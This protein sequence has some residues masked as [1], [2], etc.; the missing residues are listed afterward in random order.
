MDNYLEYIGTNI[1]AAAPTTT[2]IATGR[3]L[4]HSIVINKPLA[5]GVI[6]IYDGITAGGTL[7]GT[8]TKPAT[9]LSDIANTTIYDIICSTGIC[10]VTSGAAQ[11]ITVTWKQQ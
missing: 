3:A 11:D 9:L 8:I 2:L 6:A 10:I 7:K 1:T 4:L 5:A